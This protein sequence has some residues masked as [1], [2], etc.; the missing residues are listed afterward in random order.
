MTFLL[1]LVICAIL[2][3]L[4]LAVLLK[5]KPDVLELVT[6]LVC[7]PG[8][9]MEIQTFQAGGR[10]DRAQGLTVHAVGNGQPL[11]IKTRTLVS[12]WGICCLVTLP[13]ALYL[14]DTIMQEF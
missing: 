13:L 7:P 5:L 1:S 3:T 10:R 9:H 8:T 14:A 6:R 12:F 2:G 11:E 4:L